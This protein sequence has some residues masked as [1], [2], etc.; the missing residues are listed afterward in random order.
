MYSHEKFR[1]AESEKTKQGVK[2]KPTLQMEATSP[3]FKLTVRSV[4]CP[5]I[6]TTHALHE[7]WLTSPSKEG[8]GKVL[9]GAR[10]FSWPFCFP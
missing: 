5:F 9:T 2:W 1:D 8:L 3:S 6:L 7:K 4:L 10:I